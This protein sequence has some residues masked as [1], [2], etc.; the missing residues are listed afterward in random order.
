M[1]KTALFKK[2]KKKKR[3]S[4]EEERARRFKAGRR[5]ARGD[6]GKF[7][8]HLSF[9][10]HVGRVASLVYTSLIKGK[11]VILSPKET[12]GFYAGKGS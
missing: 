7:P 9:V 11:G 2:K 4:V 5:C 10:L 12:Q 1:V 6:E 8:R 3:K